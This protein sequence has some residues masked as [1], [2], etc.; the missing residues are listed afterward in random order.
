MMHPSMNDL[1]HWVDCRAPFDSQADFDN[2]GFLVGNRNETVQNI[3]FALDITDRVL[4][5]AV[6][7]GANLIIT[8]H[9]MM[10]SPVQCMTEDDVEGK[11]ISRMIRNHISLISAHTNLDSAQ[12]GIND[13]LA[14][15]LGLNDVHGDGY[16]RIGRF[17]EPVHFSS[18]VDHIERTLH[19]TVRIFGQAPGD[20]EITALAVSSGA[21]SDFWPEAL[22]L[23]AQAF[24]T[25]EI[26]HHH[27]LAMC[28]NG[29]IGLEGGHFATEEPGLFAL[30]DALQSYVNEVKWNVTIFKSAVGAY[31]LPAVPKAGS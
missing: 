11:L 20:L 3:L 1:Y 30:A 26:K 18:L 9:P 19:T 4:D 6:Q 23:G 25:G 17:S 13:T 24:L 28:A 8:H 12:G 22:Q 21:G 10:F 31:A 27:G 16:L 14:A 29:L 15:L 5:E 7:H 2:S